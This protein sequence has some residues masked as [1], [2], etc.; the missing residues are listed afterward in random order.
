MRIGVWDSGKR[1]LRDCGS[2]HAGLQRAW[3]RRNPSSKIQWFRDDSVVKMHLHVLATNTSPA[4]WP[5]LVCWPKKPTPAA[6]HTHSSL[7]RKSQSMNGSPTLALYRVRPMVG[8]VCLSPRACRLGTLT[9][10]K[11]SWTCEDRGMS[12]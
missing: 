8:S 7:R 11:V 1:P 10:S 2:A 9:L 6:T 5:L 12:A 4:L 3:L